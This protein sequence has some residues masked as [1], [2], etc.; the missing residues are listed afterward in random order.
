MEVALFKIDPSRIIV[1]YLGVSQEVK[2]LISELR[3]HLSVY[4]IRRSDVSRRHA[5][6]TILACKKLGVN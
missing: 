3:F 2:P 4:L 5:K 6:E 1:N